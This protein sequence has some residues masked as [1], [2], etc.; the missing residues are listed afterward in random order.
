MCI[1]AGELCKNGPF[2]DMIQGLVLSMLK[3]AMN[4]AVG[5]QEGTARA[6]CLFKIGI[7]S[8]LP[9]RI[10]GPGVP[11]DAFET[12]TQKIDATGKPV[13]DESDTDAAGRAY[14][15]FVGKSMGELMDGTQRGQTCVCLACPVAFFRAL[16]HR[17]DRF[18]HGF[19]KHMTD[20]V[21][22]IL[23]TQELSTGKVLVL[24]EL[25]GHLPS[26]A[27]DYANASARDPRTV[28]I[29]DV[30]V[31]ALAMN[32]EANQF[33]NS[34]RDISPTTRTYKVANAKYAAANREL[35]V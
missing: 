26:S 27:E 17:S 19:E 32:A 22:D 29:N 33:Y 5:E 1:H 13:W 10:G 16:D 9:R 30:L 34:N 14:S 21:E 25:P 35:K 20:L 3:S 15:T 2:R 6:D 31:K 24:A 23:K 4:T 12:R 28:S 7:T 11:F 8:C 18:S